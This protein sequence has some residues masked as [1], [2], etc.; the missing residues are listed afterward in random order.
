MILTI[1]D[2]GTGRFCSRFIFNC[3]VYHVVS[4]GV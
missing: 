4:Y 2:V 1:L 3:S